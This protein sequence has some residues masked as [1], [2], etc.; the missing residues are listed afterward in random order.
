[1]RF[2]FNQNVAYY[3]DGYLSGLASGADMVAE[4][5]CGIKPMY[6]KFCKDFIPRE[7]RVLYYQLRGKHIETTVKAS[8]TLNRNLDLIQEGETV[9]SV[10]S[11]WFFTN[12]PIEQAKRAIER[13]DSQYRRQ[14]TIDKGCSQF[15]A[16]WDEQHFVF[17]SWNE[18]LIKKLK[19]FYENT[20]AGKVTFFTRE[21][22]MW[23]SQKRPSAGIHLVDLTR[24]S[25][26]DDKVFKVLQEKQAAETVL[27]A[28]SRHFE[29]Y[30]EHRLRFG[31]K[32]FGYLRPERFAEDGK[33]VLYFLNP[34]S[35]EP[36]D[37]YGPYTAKQLL[38]WIR[39][40]KSYQLTTSSPE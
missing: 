1:M 14:I 15:F 9:S 39:H 32:V 4:H 27:Y 8:R 12:A 23:T 20:K 2:G 34:R 26:H 40:D 25:Y 19:V 5:E 10:S 37:Y 38:R 22:P 36:A 28:A 3:K 29:I 7:D 30:D 17:W 6:V 33:T 35:G 21:A 31:T 18:K 11:V 24:I 16:S 13:E